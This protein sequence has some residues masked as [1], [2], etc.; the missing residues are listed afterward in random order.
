MSYKLSHI[1]YI[2]GVDEVGRGPLA[3]PFAVGVVLVKSEMLKEGKK[4]AGEIF[5]GIKDSKQLTALGRA[6]WF[7]KIKAAHKAEKLNYKVSFVSSKRLDKIGLTATANLAIKRSLKKL[8]AMPHETLVLL[9]GGLR[10]PKEF[11]Y[12]KTIIKGDAKEPIIGLASIAAKVLRDRRMEK[13]SLEYPQFD[14]HVHKGYG[15]KRHI[16]LI[17]KFGPCEIHRKTFIKGILV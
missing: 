15:T 17:K 13:L 12:Q 5:G 10:A 14:F 7:E 6:L 11:L 9:D 3:G 1:K 8:G 16:S 2:A 4:V